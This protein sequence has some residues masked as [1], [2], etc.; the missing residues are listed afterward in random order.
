MKEKYLLEI[1]NSLFSSA[2]LYIQNVWK[3][4]LLTVRKKNIKG[5]RLEIWVY[6]KVITNE[7]F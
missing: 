2:C 7:M 6:L 3:F 1:K 5:K 4:Y